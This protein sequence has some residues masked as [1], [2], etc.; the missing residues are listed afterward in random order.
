MI[1]MFPLEGIELKTDSDNLT[2]FTAFIEGQTGS[3]YEDGLKF[4]FDFRDI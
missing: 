2:H 4:S 1:K 3:P